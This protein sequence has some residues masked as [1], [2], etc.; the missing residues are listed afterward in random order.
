MIPSDPILYG[1]TLPYGDVPV[2]TPFFG[3]F[4]PWQRFLPHAFGYGA[5]QQ[6]PWQQYAGAQQ[7]PWQQY[8]HGAAFTP[9]QPYPQVQSLPYNLP[10]NFNLLPY[11][12]NLPFYGW[13]RPFVC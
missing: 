7:L 3:Q 13:Q 12:M 4:N 1:V 8:M 2:Q 10:F 9:F 6:L 5:Y 11:N